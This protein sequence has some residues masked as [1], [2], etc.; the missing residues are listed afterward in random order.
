MFENRKNYHIL[1]IYKTKYTKQ[2]NTIIAI[3]DKK[4]ALTDPIKGNLH[5]K[6]L[7]A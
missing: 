3:R 4:Q 5:K 2:T 1:L 7:Y 6:P